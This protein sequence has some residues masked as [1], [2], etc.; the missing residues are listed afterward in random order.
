MDLPNHN[1]RDDA[2]A[3]KRLRI[4]FY[5]LL[6]FVVLLFGAATL[7][8]A[9][10]TSAV[11]TVMSY[12]LDRETMTFEMQRRVSWSSDIRAVWVTEAN[13]NG[14]QCTE[15]GASTYEKYVEDASGKP[16]LSAVGKP[17]ER[18]IVRFAP[19]QALLPC[20]TDPNATIVTRWAAHVWGPVFL[21]PV[22]RYIPARE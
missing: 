17:V 13:G 9:I 5:I 21:R 2:R 19:T 4:S 7:W 12:Q 18:I 8:M 14:L 3:L 1:H 22:V 16:L 11:L 15:S 10:P 20:L 6:G